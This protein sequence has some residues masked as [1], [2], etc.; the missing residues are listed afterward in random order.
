M[1]ASP[2]PTALLLCALLG[3]GVA[4]TPVRADAAAPIR[5]ASLDA[6]ASYPEHL[7]PATVVS[8][9]EAE[10]SAEIAARVVA[11][12]PRVGDVVA[13]GAVLAR[14]DCRDYE[15]ELEAARA[16]LA[17]LEAR[18]ELAARRLQRAQSLE[19]SNSLAVEAREE[20]EA[21]RDVLRAEIRGARA[22]LAL[23][24]IA[25]GRCTIKSPYRALLRARLAPVGQYVAVGDAVARVVDLD[26]LEL[27]AEVFAA[28]VEAIA[29]SAALIFVAGGQRYPVALRSAV[30]AI[31][32]ASRNRELRLRFDGEPPLVGSAGQLTWSDPRPH[33]PGAV[34]VRRGETLGLFTVS[35]GR[36]RFV[37]LPEA[38]AGRA[39][40]VTLPG[41]SRIVTEGQYGLRDGQAVSELGAP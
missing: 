38:Q 21:E 6:I 14:L 18:L 8:G 34:L 33:V 37:A 16:A 2:L 23:D 29:R 3:A 10:I 32:T 30:Q 5:S 35:D 17:V 4:P 27:S 31:N 41:D 19:R 12:A 40:P 9:S 36:A 24:E 1:R 22:R 39:S 28:D 26:D 13:A 15:L 7:A 25:V 11:F 20:R